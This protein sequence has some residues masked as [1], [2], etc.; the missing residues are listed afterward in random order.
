MHD[1]IELGGDTLPNDLRKF[2]EYK[3]ATTRRE[4]P[5]F[6][7]V[8]DL[9]KEGIQLHE[10]QHPI[11][12]EKDQRK[13]LVETDDLKEDDNELNYMVITSVAK[14]FS[15][16]P[17][18]DLL[19]SDKSYISNILKNT[20]NI[21]DNHEELNEKREKVQTMKINMYRRLQ[22][23]VDEAKDDMEIHLR[24]Q[25]TLAEHSAKTAARWKRIK[26]LA[27]DIEIALQ[28]VTK[29]TFDKQNI[30]AKVRELQAKRREAENAYEK[31]WKEAIEKVKR[32]RSAP[33]KSVFDAT[34]V[35]LK[36]KS[37]SLKIQ[38]ALNF[39]KLYSQHGTKSSNR[40][41]REKQI[42]ESRNIEAE[43]SALRAATS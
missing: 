25:Q 22:K 12:E 34:S 17:H 38:Q 36:S 20:P 39:Q 42:E 29:E 7:D 13:R 21:E 37:K 2:A 8:H 1:I 5:K 43:L 15:V 32:Y 9:L 28:D 27:E 3:L 26:L 6:E 35:L 18:A 33:P 40:R 30:K 16:D 4:W 11:K 41:H 23:Y 14:K 24:H 19:S 10:K 31:K